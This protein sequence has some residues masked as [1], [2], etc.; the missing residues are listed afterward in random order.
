MLLTNDI[1]I[2]RHECLLTSSLVPYHTHH[3]T[4]TTWHTPHHI[5]HTST[6]Y[7]II[8]IKSFTTSH[9]S[10]NIVHSHYCALSRGNTTNT[11]MCVIFLGGGGVGGLR[12]LW[13]S[14]IAYDSRWF[15][16]SLLHMYVIK[17]SQQSKINHILSS[18][19]LLIQNFL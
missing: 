7:L 18:T 14:R 4:P 13:G 10:Y 3:I 2:S 8:I 1:S 6:I 16:T 17:I 15:K 5:I 12:Q 19:V 11:H 9:T